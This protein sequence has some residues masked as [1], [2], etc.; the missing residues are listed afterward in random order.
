[1]NFEIFFSNLKEAFIVD[2][3]S[4]NVVK[5]HGWS[6]GH[7]GYPTANICGAKIE[8]HRFLMGAAPKGMVIDHINGN[9]LDNRYSNL[10]FCTRSQNQCNKAMSCTNLSG[11]KGVI[12]SHGKFVARIAFQGQTLRLGTFNTAI[13]AAHAYDKKAL[14][15]HGEFARLNFPKE[16]V[17]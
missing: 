15:L 8:L 16:K 17:A 5:N 12:I 1:M 6:K 2:E 14:E 7:H 11:Y 3:S 10:R 9:K 4:F 13:D